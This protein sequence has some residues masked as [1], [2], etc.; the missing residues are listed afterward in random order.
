M[1]ELKKAI[2]EEAGNHE[3]QIQEMRQRHSAALEELSEQLE[4]ARKVRPGPDPRP[5]DPL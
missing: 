1:A 2:E 3:G 4:Q 5:P